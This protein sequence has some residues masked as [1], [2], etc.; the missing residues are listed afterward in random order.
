MSVASFRTPLGLC[1][2][3]GDD[4]GVSSIQITPES[5]RPDDIPTEL[6]EAVNQM[7]EYFDGLRTE[8]TFKT[9]Q[10]EHHSSNRFGKSYGRF[11]LGRQYLI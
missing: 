3:E 10:K 1:L 11:H 6:F 5:D 8:F 4:H 2:L 9:I 7:R